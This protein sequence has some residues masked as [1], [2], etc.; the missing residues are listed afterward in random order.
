MHFI[1]ISNQ[2]VLTVIIEVKCNTD[3]FKKAFS[4]LSFKKKRVLC[5]ITFRTLLYKHNGNT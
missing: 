5:K 1:S 3:E 4:F 2:C